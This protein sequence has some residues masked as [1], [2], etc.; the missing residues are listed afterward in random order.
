MLRAG[1][2]HW[3]AR[4]TSLPASSIHS[5]HHRY[6]QNRRQVIPH[7]AADTHHQTSS[8]RVHSELS[9]I[10]HTYLGCG[11]AAPSAPQSNPGLTVHMHL[12]APN[13]RLLHMPMQGN[14]IFTCKNSGSSEDIHRTN[15]EQCKTCETSVSWW[16]V[17]ADDE[18]S[19]DDDVGNSPSPSYTHCCGLR[20]VLV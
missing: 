5:A 2:T 18:G 19:F 20:M 15:E 3:H 13:T 1:R 17:C 11:R 14:Q 16:K 7:I 6:S 8:Q 4:Y 12:H 10:L 9:L